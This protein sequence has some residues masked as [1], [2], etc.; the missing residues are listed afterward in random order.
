MTS[1]TFFAEIENQWV[2]FPMHRIEAESINMKLNAGKFQMV[3]R[4]GIR[5]SDFPLGQHADTSKTAIQLDE[6][7]DG[8]N[9]N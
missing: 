9:R 8:P 2:E 7:T 4:F 1:L 5:I 6:H 3:P